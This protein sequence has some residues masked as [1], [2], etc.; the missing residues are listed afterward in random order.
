[1][2]PMSDNAKRNFEQLLRKLAAPPTADKPD[3]LAEGTLVDGRYRVRQ[4]LGEGGMGEVYEV[5]HVR[6]GRVLAL[7]CMRRELAG[8]REA[9]LRFQAE[10]KAAARIGSKH[11]VEVTDLGDLADGRP[12]LCME[13]LDGFTWEEELGGVPQSPPLVVHVVTQLCD[14]L[15]VAHAEG[16]VHR[17]LKPSNVF[18]VHETGDS[19]FVKLTDFGVA[20]MLVSHGMRLTS[21]GVPLGTPHYMAPEQAL[22]DKNLD[23]RVDIYGLGVMLYQ[24]LSGALPFEEPNFARLV[25]RICTEDA[26][27]LAARCPQLDPDLCTIVQQSMARDPAQRFSHCTALKHALSGYR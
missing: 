13:L 5:E 11:I 19:R 8:D 7:K 15:S 6:I 12:Y 16:I 17:D 1:M 18:L 9:L 23:H 24:A 22:G 26:P 4:K 2:H 10:A 27:D 20:K 14:A 3:N 21:T 25:T